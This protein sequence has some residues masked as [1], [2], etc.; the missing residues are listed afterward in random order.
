MFIPLLN[1]HI[2]RIQVWIHSP[3]NESLNDE[4]ANKYYPD[5]KNQ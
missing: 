2:S 3:S 5:Y 1:V 4:N